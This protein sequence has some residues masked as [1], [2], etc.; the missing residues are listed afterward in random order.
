MTYA[1]VYN[2]S[3]KLL[4]SAAD[5]INFMRANY[6][7]GTVVQKTPGGAISKLKGLFGGNKEEKTNY[8]YLDMSKLE[9]NN[10]L[11]NTRAAKLLNFR[12]SLQNT[13]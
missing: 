5:I 12:W 4:T 8:R 13:K 3:D 1:G 10:M 11:D 2:V 7:L 9:N 6:H